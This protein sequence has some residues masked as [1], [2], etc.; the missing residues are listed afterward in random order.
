MLLYVFHY[1]CILEISIICLIFFFFFS[2]RRRH[3][4]CALV[5]GVQT[6]ALP[7]LRLPNVPTSRRA[8]TRP[9]NGRPSRTI[10]REGTMTDRDPR[11]PLRPTRRSILKGKAVG[12]G[13]AFLSGVAPIHFVRNAWAQAYPALGNFPVEGSTVTYGF[14]PPLTCPYP[15]EGRDTLTAYQLAVQH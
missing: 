9:G 3:T 6:C 7:I 13:A 2:S 8:G 12:A 11:K 1:L 10:N 15:D 14:V 5:T 4:R